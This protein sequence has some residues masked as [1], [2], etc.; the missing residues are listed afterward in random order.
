MRM[1]VA[2]YHGG[3]DRKQKVETLRY[4]VKSLTAGHFV[5]RGLTRVARQGYDCI[6]APE[7]DGE[8]SLNVVLRLQSPTIAANT[9]VWATP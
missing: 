7:D 3:L 5:H 1:P 4:A 2:V 9:P 8:W 6:A